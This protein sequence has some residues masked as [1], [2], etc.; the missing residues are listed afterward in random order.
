MP[1]K[2]EFPGAFLK[3]WVSHENED[4][5]EALGEAL[6]RKCVA[7][8]ALLAAQLRKAAPIDR[9]EF[10]GATSRGPNLR[11][12][13][14]AREHPYWVSIP[15]IPDSG[16]PTPMLV[17]L[18]RRLSDLGLEPYTYG[19]AHM[20]YV[21][22]RQ[23][24]DRVTARAMLEESVFWQMKTD[25]SAADLAMA[26]AAHADT[27]CRVKSWGEAE[28][29]AD[30]AIAAFIAEPRIAHIYGGSINDV[31][32]HI[33]RT[34]VTVSAHRV[35]SRNYWLVLNWIRALG[36][37]GPE[38]RP[39]IDFVAVRA[40]LLAEAVDRRHRSLQRRIVQA[41]DQHFPDPEEQ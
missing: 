26:H 37:V 8:L 10:K 9:P 21:L 23:A 27:L 32:A 22:G 25:Y 14:V 2:G 28:R 34:V 4:P 1:G 19:L 12:F 30:A 33:S 31:A 11:S 18:L 41:C 35:L 20:L 13:F 39:S 15:E 3:F 17:A 38:A 36:N 40:T 29:A 24:T 5:S 16:Q 6:P 7:T